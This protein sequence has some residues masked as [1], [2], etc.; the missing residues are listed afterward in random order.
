MKKKSIISSFP[1]PLFP[2]PLPPSIPKGKVRFCA[3][4]TFSTIFV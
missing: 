2:K 1:G 3:A 4:F